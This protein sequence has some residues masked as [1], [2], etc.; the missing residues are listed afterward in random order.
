[1]NLRR[2]W[3]CVCKRR[4]MQ[5]RSGEQGNSRC[6]CYASDEIPPT[7]IVYQRAGNST[8]A[9]YGASACAAA[10]NTCRSGWCDAISTRTRRV[11][12]TTAVEESKSTGIARVNVPALRG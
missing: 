5:A 9:G 10:K 7:P 11:L 3:F 12:R 6:N 8:R 1:M 2:P 4:E